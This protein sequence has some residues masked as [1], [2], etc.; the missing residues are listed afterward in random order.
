MEYDGL[1]AQGGWDRYQIIRRT[2]L[3][4]PDFSGWYAQAAYSLTGETHRYDPTTASFR[5]LRPAHPLGRGRLGRLEITARY[6]DL[7]LDFHAPQKR[8]RGRRARRQA[9]C[10]DGGR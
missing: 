9:E 10:L 5:N 4:N 6:S 7:D 8:G 2:S 1:Y 3:P